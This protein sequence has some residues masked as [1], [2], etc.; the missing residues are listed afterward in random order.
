MSAIIAV[1]FCIG[2]ALGC[3]VA[4]MIADSNQWEREHEE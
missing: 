1:A 2:F 4:T 3:I